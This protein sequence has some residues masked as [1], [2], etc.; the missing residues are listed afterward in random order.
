MGI[1]NIQLVQVKEVMDSMTST[2][3]TNSI[4]I[5]SVVD[6]IIKNHVNANEELNMNPNLARQKGDPL[7]DDSTAK[8]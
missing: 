2:N 3:S 5:N 4:N 6:S 1:I 7:D 8:G